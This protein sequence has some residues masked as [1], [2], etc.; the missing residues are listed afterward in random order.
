MN[1]FI[2]TNLDIPSNYKYLFI[3]FKFL[4]EWNKK[5]YY[6]GILEVNLL[7]LLKRW[8]RL[9]KSHMNWWQKMLSNNKQEPKNIFKWTHLVRF[10]SWCMEVLKLVKAMPSWFICVKY[11]IRFQNTT[12]D[13][14][15]NKEPKPINFFL[16]INII[17]DPLCLKLS[18]LKFMEA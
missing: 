15:L 14:L 11:L 16:G 6:I 5:L 3:F 2:F 10:H 7:E 4:Q 8:Y 13:Q 17:L 9:A 18:R 12:M 1:R